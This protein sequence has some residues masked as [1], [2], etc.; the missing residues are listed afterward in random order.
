[1]KF[2]CGLV[3]SI[4]IICMS[5]VPSVCGAT[6]DFNDT[7]DLPPV[8][9]NTDGW[10]F[11]TANGTS[12]A[13]GCEEYIVDPDR[14]ALTYLPSGTSGT[15]LVSERVFSARAGLFVIDFEVAFKTKGSSNLLYAYQGSQ[16]LFSVSTDP[17]KITGY[18]GTGE[19]DNSAVTMT[20][21]SSYTTYKAYHFQIA[22]NSQDNIFNMFINGEPVA[23]NVPLRNRITTGMSKAALFQAGDSSAQWQLANFGIYTP[24]SAPSV[25]NICADKTPY[26]GRTVNAEYVFDGDSFDDSE[27]RWMCSDSAEGVYEY[28]SDKPEKSFTVTHFLAGKWFKAEVV[29]RDGMFLSGNPVYSAPVKDMTDTEISVDKNS[30]YALKYNATRDESGDMTILE[31]RDSQ[32]GEAVVEPLKNV[33]GTVVF[34]ASIKNKTKDSA[35]AFYVYQDGNYVFNITFDA[36]NINLLCSSEPGKNTYLHQKLV[37]GYVA[38][39]WYDIGAI[40]DTETNT[41]DFYVNGELVFEDVGMRVALTKG[42]TKILSMRPGTSD[43]ETYIKGLRLYSV[44]VPEHRPATVKI[45]DIIM[46]TDNGTGCARLS[47]KMF[48]QFGEKIDNADFEWKLEE[49]IEDVS[50][51]YGGV[52]VIK[53][54]AFNKKIKV[55]ALSAENPEVFGSTTVSVNKRIEVSRFDIFADDGKELAVLDRS[56]TAT[57]TADVTV[58]SGAKEVAVLIAFYDASGKLMSANIEKYTPGYDDKMTVTSSL[59]VEYNNDSKGGY[60]KA[61]VFDNLNHIKP[62]TESISSRK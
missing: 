5:V 35:N 30:V 62:L 13:I 44:S 17:N 38:D 11:K 22:V 52:L 15:T 4:C 2:L 37:R 6:A 58:S 39:T 24:A 55:T 27:V 3:V 32:G 53:R 18:V 33:T 26:L 49:D 54:S 36:N 29:P 60:F 7:F 14:Q 51:Q 25:S 57:A 21:L 16:Y 56:L 1:M 10:I 20:Y 59:G 41:A 42:I 19:Y 45:D 8:E 48:D 43:G 34:E 50:L 28:I 46:Y 61:F 47:A 23:L 40:I 31:T 12:G 9:S